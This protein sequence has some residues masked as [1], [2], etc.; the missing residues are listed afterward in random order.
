MRY[1]LRTLLIVLALGPPVLAGG[2]YGIEKYRAWLRRDIWEN[3]A[4]PGLID[5][6]GGGTGL[7]VDEE[8]NVY[9]KA[10]GDDDGTESK[11]T[12]P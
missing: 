2:W 10:V 8:G 6:F 12:S 5:S 3:V 4:G 1:R 7:F 11:S 9:C